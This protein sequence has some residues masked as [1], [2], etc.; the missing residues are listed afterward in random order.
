MK[1]LL[2]ILGFVGLMATM[3]AQDANLVRGNDPK[4]GVSRSSIRAGEFYGEL[5]VRKQGNLELIRFE[6]DDV[7]LR[8]TR[9]AQLKVTFQEL[10][11]HRYQTL[12]EALNI[13]ASHGWEVRNGMVTKGRQGD[14][15]HYLL[16]RP[17]DYVLPL[18]PWKDNQ[19]GSNSGKQ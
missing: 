3:N 15:E 14:E 10:K 7:A 2:T 16:A 1:T 12:T 9:D 11:S 17:V 4:G 13:L 19:R 8:M 6:L 5:V 18:T